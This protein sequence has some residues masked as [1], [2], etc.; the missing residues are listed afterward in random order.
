MKLKMALSRTAMLAALLAALAA[1]PVRAADVESG[2]W[3]ETDSSNTSLS[4]YPGWPSSTMLPTQ[5]EPSG[6]AMM[7]AVKRFRDRVDGLL[8][9]SGSAGSY[10]LTYSVAPGAYIQGQKFTF[11]A[12]FTSVGGDTLNVNS[13]GALPLYKP[14]TS[15][16]VAIAAGDI[17]SGQ[18]V[19]ASYD[20][21][22]DSSGGGFHVLEGLPQLS[23]AGQSA[24][25]DLSG[26]Y[27]NPTVAQLTGL[28]V[29]AA[30]RGFIDGF[31]TGAPGG[32]QTL[33]IGP[34]AAVD[35]TDAY[36]LS[37]TSSFTK[38]MA[39]WEVGSGNGCLDT[40]TVAESTAYFFYTIK[41]TDT[42]VEDYLCSLSNSSPTLPTNYSVVRGPISWFKT[43]SS[44]NIWK[45]QQRGDRFILGASAADV[46]GASIGTGGRTL[47]ALSVPSGFVVEALMRVSA[48]GNVNSTGFQL[49]VTSPDETDQAA[50]GSFSDIAVPVNTNS[51]TSS[52]A[53][54]LDVQRRTN[55]SAEVGFRSGGAGATVYESTYGFVW[56]RGRDS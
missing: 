44:S 39:S 27:P 33:T 14:S 1:A 31:E 20:S 16:P 55:T 3:S 45:F 50:S 2:T 22:L 35:N 43:D 49:L 54:T 30:L 29:G 12:N 24:G 56:T 11:R 23:F 28:P 47:E 37:V 15:G 8:T 7:G 13:L 5:V 40:G 26:T 6:R 51:S 19:E 17:Q 10:A 41:R 38:T 52:V 46:N 18:M 25:G 4:P 21:N 36:L 32:G 9:S 34:G 48:T 53:V 42:G